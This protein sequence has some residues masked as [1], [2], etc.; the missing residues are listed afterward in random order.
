ML[1]IHFTNCLVDAVG[2]AHGLTEPELFG[3]ETRLREAHQ[4]VMRQANTGKLGFVDLPN[5][6]EEARKILSWAKKARTSFD[7]LVVLGIGGS[8]LGPIA[9]QQAVNPPYWNLH[10]KKARKGA[11]RLFV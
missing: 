10:D 4:N 5:N 1:S 2:L 11:L 7:T 3:M 8:A 6:S 9:V